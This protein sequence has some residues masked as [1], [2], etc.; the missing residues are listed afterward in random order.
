M[1]STAIDTQ[2]TWRKVLNFPL[3]TLILA[4]VVFMATMT[5]SALAAKPIP[6]P[7]G[8]QQIVLKLIGCVLLIV[9]YKFVI[10]RMGEIKRDDLRMPGAMR[11]LG[12]GLAVGA[13]IM[14]AVA[15]IAAVL[16]VYSIAGPGDTVAL[17]PEIIALGVFPAISE[18]I[19]F[20][21]ILFRWIEELGGSWFALAAT[22]AFFGLA[23]FYNPNAS[24]FTSFAIAVE[25]GLLLGGTYMLTRSLWLPIGLHAGWNL[26]QGEILDVNVSGLTMDGLVD[27]RTSGSELLSG[28]QFGFEGSIIALILATAVGLWYVIRAVNKGE[29]MRPWWVRRRLAREAVAVEQPA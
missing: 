22:S 5:V 2:P 25:A 18:E 14:F 27:A 16:R 21:G 9:A 24:L 17:F 1:A 12:I 4:T 28:G 26:T 19:F 8:S 13:A 11:N 10:A 23:H 6:D 20:R 29:V 15:I 3:V 7:T